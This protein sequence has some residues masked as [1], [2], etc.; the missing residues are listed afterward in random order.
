MP[1]ASSANS[2]Y[3]H[4]S[5]NFPNMPQPEHHSGHNTKLRGA[6]G[7]DT[8]FNYYVSYVMQEDFVST[9]EVFSKFCPYN[10]DSKR[11]LSDRISHA[12]QIIGVK[13]IIY[14]DDRKIVF[15]MLLDYFHGVGGHTFLPGE[16]FDLMKYFKSEY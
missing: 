15:C 13:T 14:D 11:E 12:I 5:T 3:P 10:G 7:D 4:D 16:I 8:R 2:P 9:P 6:Y 1:V